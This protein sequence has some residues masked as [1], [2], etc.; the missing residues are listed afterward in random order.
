MDSPII[1]GKFSHGRFENPM[2]ARLRKLYLED[3]MSTSKEM[4]FYTKAKENGKL[5]L[6]LIKGCQLSNILSCVVS[7]K[8]THTHENWT[9]R[10]FENILNSLQSGK[11][12]HMLKNKF[13][14]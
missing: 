2:Q 10:R 7:S 8:N 13:H 9:I 12:Y 6:T 11:Y 4:L 1:P 14:K 5:Y 3:V